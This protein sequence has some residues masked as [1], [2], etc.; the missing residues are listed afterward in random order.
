MTAAAAAAATPTTPGGKVWKAEA[1]GRGTVWGASLPSIII[2][3][4][5]PQ[6]TAALV[7][8]L[9]ALP[10]S[11]PSYPALVV[12]TTGSDLPKEALKAYSAKAAVVVCANFSTGVPLLLKVLGGLKGALPAGWHGEVT[13]MHHTAKLDAP[14]GTGKR[15][16]GALEGAGV[17]G[18]GGVSPPPCHALRLGDTIGTHTVH[19]AGPGERLEITHTA[20]RRD[21][22]ATGALRVAEWAATLKP[23]YQEI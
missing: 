17:T 21:V 14:S 8:S 13:E 16:Q 20:T 10:A 3:V 19:L 1:L 7:A 12:G 9:L 15:I 23:G 18:F 11:T 6:G 22:F 5:L 4:S 2:D